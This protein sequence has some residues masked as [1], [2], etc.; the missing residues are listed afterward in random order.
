MPRLRPRRLGRTLLILLLIVVVVLVGLVFY[1]DGQLR[2]VDALPSYAGRPANTPGT[3]W[4]VVGSDSRSDLSAAQK[5][6]LA[7]GDADGSRTDT[8]MLVYKPPSGTAAMVSVPRDLYVPVPGQGE[9]KINAAFNLGG[10]R[11][12]VQTIEQLSGVRIDHYAEIGFGGFDAL[13]NAVGGVEMCIDQPLNDPKA[14]LRLPAG[15]QT[16]DGAQALGFVRTRAFAN[17]DL[18]RVSNQRKFLSALMSRATSPSVLLNPF[19]LFPFV[20]GTVNTLTVDNGT[21]IWD[22]A[23]LA[24]WLRGSPVTITTPNGGPVSTWDGDSLLVDDSTT[25]FFEK[26][27]TGRELGQSDGAPSP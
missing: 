3:T 23:R 17:A 25:A 12:L 8:I 15:C 19:R 14:G 18:V 9:Y 4:L 6:N 1:Y 22:L 21:H 16:L 10:P 5:E 27:R 20:S 11:L 26:M 7:T 24:L 2:R 13:V